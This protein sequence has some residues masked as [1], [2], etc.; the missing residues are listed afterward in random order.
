MVADTS[1]SSSSDGLTL[2]HAAAARMVASPG[3]VSAVVS[4]PQRAPLMNWACC[5][6]S[7]LVANRLLEPFWTAFGG[8]AYASELMTM[9]DRVGE[10]PSA[11]SSRLVMAH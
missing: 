2:N 4:S 11:I 7:S 10:L 6:R 9:L 8:T 5:I 1:A 3:I